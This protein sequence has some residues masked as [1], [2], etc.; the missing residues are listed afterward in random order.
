MRLSAIDALQHGL[1]NLRA[2]WQ[3]IFVQALQSLLVMVIGVVGLVP[4]FMVLGFTF[5]RETLATVGSGGEAELLERVLGAGVPLIVAFLITTL[6]WTIA[7]VVYC[8]MQGGMLGVLAGGE[9]KARR[10]G[11]RWLNFRDFSTRGFLVYAEGLTWPIFW[12]INVFLLLATVVLL[13]FAVAAAGL[14][15]LMIGDGFASG[16]GFGSFGELGAGVLLLGCFGIV[17]VMVFT[18]FFSVWMQVGLAELAIGTRGVLAATRAALATVGRRL[19][20]LALLL[21]LLMVAS[22]AMAMVI[23]PVSLVMEAALEDRM[24][25]YLVGRAFLTLFQWLGAGI[26]SLGWA[27]T[28]IALV[29]GEHEE[30]A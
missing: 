5:M 20:G 22:I 28:V 16:N 19:P 13:F 7:F 4:I 12:L 30:R 11:V 26:V 25:T 14:L 27:G 9:R 15:T 23:A 3:L 24:T 8:Y 10:E 21:L 18:I 17:L 6:I 1:L 29:L 2:N